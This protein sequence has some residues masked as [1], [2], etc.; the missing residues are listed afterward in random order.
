MLLICFTAPIEVVSEANK[1]E[2]WVLSHK[3]HKKQKR[4]IAF[5]LSQL[6]LYRDMPLTIKLIRIS[7]RKLDMKDNLPMAF[8]WI[9]DAIAD[10]LIPGKAAGR[11]DDSPLF[12]WQYEQEKGK[13]K[14]KAIR[15]EVYERKNSSANDSI[16]REPIS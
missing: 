6:S 13:V 3:R 10:I 8:K 14:E 1:C 16:I 7:P 2:H 15:V 11:A 12:N 4:Y 9:A 5:Y